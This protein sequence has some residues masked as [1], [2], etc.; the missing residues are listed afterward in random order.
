M[1]Q[2]CNGT[3]AESLTQLS[4]KISGKRALGDSGVTIEVTK[5][6]VG[7]DAVVVP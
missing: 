4:G 1:S 6:V 5:R 3:L 2:K 7:R